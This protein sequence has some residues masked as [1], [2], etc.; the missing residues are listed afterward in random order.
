M[1]NLSEYQRIF[2]IKSTTERCKTVYDTMDRVW[3]EE[4]DELARTLVGQDYRIATYGQTL[5]TTYHDSLNPKY[6]DQK[7][8]TSIGKRYFAQIV[9]KISGTDVTL[10]TLEFNGVEKQLYVYSELSF[11]QAYELIRTGNLNSMLGELEPDIK[12]FMRTSAFTK[13]EIE[14]SILEQTMRDMMKPR[15]RPWIYFGL[16]IPLEGE[17]AVTDIV[18]LLRQTWEQ[19]AAIRDCALEDKYQ[20]VRAA[21]IMELISS[22]EAIYQISLLGHSYQ[23]HYGVVENE[24]SGTRKQSFTLKREGQTIVQGSFDYSEYDVKSASSKPML[25]VNVEGNNHIYANV[26]VLLDDDRKEWWIQKS[27]KTQNQD[28]E[29]LKARAIELLKQHGISVREDNEYFMGTYVNAERRFEEDLAKIKGDFACAALLFAHVSGRGKLKF[30][31]T[32]DL[33]GGSDV[34]VAPKNAGNA[35]KFNEGV[36]GLEYNSNFSFSVIYDAIQNCSLTFDKDL[37]RDLHLNLTALDDKHFVILSGISGTG[38]T[39]L[40]KLYANAVYGMSYEADNPYLSIIPVRPDWT[41]AT[42]LFGYY[43]SFEHRYMITEFLKVLLHAHEEREK[44]HFIVLDEMNLARVEYYLSDYLSGVESHKEIPLHNREDLEGIPSRISIPPN[45]YLI[46]TVNVDETTHSIS[47]KVLDRAFVMTLSDVDLETFW[48]RVD[49]GI[50]AGLQDEFLFLKRLHGW[51]AP[52]HLHFGYRTMNEMIQKMS[53][54]ITLDV[55]HQASRKAMLDRVISEKVLPK[56]RG[57]DR[58]AE[59]L[60]ELREAFAAHLGEESASHGH[61]GRMEKELMRYGATQFWR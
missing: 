41:D 55:E 25:G 34:A 23:I 58:I 54:H 28:N 59:L 57:D 2:E 20:T 37:I 33:S 32:K 6:A 52:Y 18:N 11:Y 46:G 26:A 56:L 12:T 4:L 16:V 48:S 3:K 31:E 35:G 24:K 13:D 60:V 36:E 49:D 27:F 9:R 21:H 61:I 29:D 10:L 7:K 14:R 39:Q 47:D 22:V 44:P 15:N 53:R 1:I 8:D 38:K 17:C 45:V 42:A 40:A 51:L 43:S 30:L 50:R 5:M 19:T